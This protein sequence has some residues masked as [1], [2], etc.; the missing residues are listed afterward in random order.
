MKIIQGVVV[1]ISNTERLHKVFSLVHTDKRNRLAHERATQFSQAAFWLRSMRLPAKASDASV[2]DFTVEEGLPAEAYENFMEA[3]TA[4][5]AT[6]AAVRAGADVQETEEALEAAGTDG[7]DVDDSM[8]QELSSPEQDEDEPNNG[9]TE[10]AAS[11]SSSQ[12]SSEAGRH[13]VLTE[14]GEV[15]RTRRKL[16]M[17]E[18]MRNGLEELGMSNFMQ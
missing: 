1:T 14:A 16:R 4:E 3:L 10:P 18:R 6:V 12:A 9:D 13:F 7:A 2:G 15:Q 11:S 5:A 17:T 8:A